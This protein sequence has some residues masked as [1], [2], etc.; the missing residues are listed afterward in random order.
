M[1]TFV[2][3]LGPSPA[4]SVNGYSSGINK[5]EEYLPATHAWHEA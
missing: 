3:V 5:T 2:F 1:T 4:V